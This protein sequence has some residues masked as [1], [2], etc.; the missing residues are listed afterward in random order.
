MGKSMRAIQ[1][2]CGAWKRGE[3]DCNHELP[4]NAQSTCGSLVLLQSLQ[5]TRQHHVQELFPIFT[6]TQGSRSKNK[7]K[8]AEEENSIPK[9]NI[10]LIGK[11]GLT[12][13]PVSFQNVS[14]WECRFLEY[15]DPVP[16]PRSKTPVSCDPIVRRLRITESPFREAAATCFTEQI[17]QSRKLALAA[18]VLPSDLRMI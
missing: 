8:Q 11:C 9:H 10:R 12:V 3:N 14:L 5:Q 4:I 15:H 7:A 18:S 16:P 2:L 17:R 13:G 6:T 1:A